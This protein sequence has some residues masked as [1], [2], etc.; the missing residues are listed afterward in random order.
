MR[1]LIRLL[2]AIWIVTLVLT[3]AFTF[4]Q[5]RAERQRLIEDLARRG[6]LLGEGLKEAVEPAMRRGSITGVVRVLKKFATPE[7]RL[8]VYDALGNVIAAAPTE[9]VA[10]IPEVS[11]ALSRNTTIRGLRGPE[12]ARMYLYVVVLQNDGR[13][14]GALAVLLDA[15]HV[16][17][18]ENVLWQSNSVRFAALAAALSLVTL[19]VVRASVTRPLTAM[20]DWARTLKRGVAA[21]PPAAADVSM[22]GPLAIEMTGLA[23]TLYRAQAAA[24]TEASLRMRGESIWTEERLRQFLKRRLAERSLFVVSN[25]QPV[26]HVRTVTGRVVE[27]TPASGVVTALDP[28]MRTCGGVWVAHGSGDA[29]RH[30]AD[31]EG[32]LSLPTGDP[33]YT[34][35]RVWLSAEEE[36]GYYY[37]FANEGLWPLC[38]VVHQRPVFRTEDWEHYRAVNRKF[39]D[40]LLEE[41]D[42]CDAPLVLVQDYHFALLPALVK[43]ERPDARVALFWHIPWPNSEAFDICPWQDSILLGML[44]ADVVGFHT[45]YHCNNFLETV[46]RSL[47]ARIDTE[48]FAVVRGRKT[49]LVK[50]F[51]IS[52]SPWDG[53]EVRASRRELLGALGIDAEF[54]G[55]GVERVDYT[56]GLPERFAALRRFFERY[57]HYRE[58]L[59]FVQ[60]AA[61]SRTRI[62]RYRQH[63]EAVAAAAAAVNKDLRTPGWQPIVYVERHHDRDEIHRLYRHADFC[64]VTS[65]HDGMNLVAKEFVGARQDGDGVLILSRLTGASRELRDAI[66]VNPYDVDATSEAIRTAIEMP[67]AER[68]A[69]M[70]RMHAWVRE[71][72]IYRWAGHLV[73]ELSRVPESAPAG[74]P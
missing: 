70:Q 62:A 54:L 5:A 31:A 61:P 42:G 15:R 9:A 22:F 46:D 68:R 24:A 73:D 60:L 36:T 11:E 40:A 33:R 13:S 63:Q 1:I 8:L 26:S 16:D 69:R 14:V 28:V 74:T 41:M 10:A 56:K 4:I 29:D 18:T 21:P 25:R 47:E 55:V 35:R 12:H 6:T 71:H 53:E 23:R 20:A 3:A 45:Q 39:A 51:P 34:L 52:I 59:V 72:N 64:M 49:T 30:A 27:Q 2:G 67:A 43:A 58:R 48:H 17:A 50:P 7:R 44:G 19:L 66:L 32:R 65:L 57:P 38:H 37:G